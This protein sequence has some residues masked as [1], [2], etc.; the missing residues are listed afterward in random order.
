M[1]TDEYSHTVH[2]RVALTHYGWKGKTH[3]QPQ[4]CG[5]V[6]NAGFHFT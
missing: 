2:D 4:L 3:H 1:E 5:E 6:N